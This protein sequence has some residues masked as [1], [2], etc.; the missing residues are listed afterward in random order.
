MTSDEDAIAFDPLPFSLR[1]QPQRPGE[2]A[3]L[4]EVDAD[5][6]VAARL[7]EDARAAGLPLELALYIAVEA[8]RALAE[9]VAAVGVAHGELVAFLDAAGAD[10]ERHVEH[11]LARPLGEYGRGI[12]E[13]L[14]DPDVDGPL[15]ARVPHRVAAAWVHAAAAAGAPFDRW[16]ADTVANATPNRV[17]WEAAAARAGRSLGEWVLLQAARCARSRSTSP[18]TTASG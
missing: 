2:L 18:Q 14:L 17:G 5:A 8:E 10:H 4:L 3:E 16:L 7:R 6:A 9:A 1:L 12:Q 11:M 13:G 15:R